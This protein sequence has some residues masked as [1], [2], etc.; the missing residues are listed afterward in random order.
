[1]NHPHIRDYQ[2]KVIHMIG[3]GGSSMSGL[4]EM[5]VE[6]GYSVR[7]SDGAES[8]VV[9]MLQEKG[10]EVTVGH[11]AS[12]VLGA[13]LI[14]YTAAIAPDNVERVE[15]ER[16]AIPSMERKTLLGQIMEH[17]A[18]N[19]CIA[20]TH[21]KTTTSAM[22]AKVL[23]DAG[24]NPSVHIGGAADSIGGSTRL[25]SDKLFVA[26]ACEFNASFMSMNPHI[27]ILLN[28]KEDHLDFYK[29]IE[30]IENAFRAF[31]NKLPEDGWAIAC[32][33]DE[34]AK[35][36]ALKHKNHVFFGFG[37]E[38]DYY[39]HNIVFDERGCAGFDLVHKGKVEAQI[40]LIVPGRIQILDAIAAYVAGRVL[41]AEPSVLAASLGSF[42]GV[43]RRF[44]LTGIYDG[45]KV[46]HD[47]GH[48]PE[49]MLQVLETAKRLPHN[50]LWAV[51]QPHT[52][53][54]VKR[55]FPDYITCT[56]PA[57]IT[58][59]TDICAAREKDPGDIHATHIT[60]AMQKAGVPCAYTPSFDDTENYLKAHWQPGDIVVT[61]G[62][63]DINKLNIQ[64]EKHAN[65]HRTI[66]TGDTSKHG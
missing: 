10:I 11:S 42:G 61:L 9:D 55:L 12:N 63:G 56:A 8:Y 40:Q 7:G 16:R 35:R 43:H 34:R 39:P 46:Y 22:V 21:G 66:S 5:L 57:D 58:L 30:D 44:E 3:I 18:C 29:D 36:I 20:G 48:N 17:Y 33:D 38:N 1:M 27:A 19:V 50:R 31:L 54:R 26:E 52:Y 62:C 14:I 2:H 37:E 15:A 45:V 49:E 13:D 41:G 24:L 65:Q 64:M 32:G 53:S 60:D 28:V 25:G 47:Y 51:M 59:V 6:L 23:L 4:A